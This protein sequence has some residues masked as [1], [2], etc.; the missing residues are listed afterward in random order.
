[1]LALD[2]VVVDPVAKQ[3]AAAAAAPAAGAAAAAGATAGAGAEGRRSEGCERSEQDALERSVHSPP[4][5][6]LP[7]EHSLCADACGASTG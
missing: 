3:E 7:F 6:G 1:L 2:P 4:R 5:G